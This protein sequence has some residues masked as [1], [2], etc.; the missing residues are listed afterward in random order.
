MVCGPCHYSKLLSPLISERSFSQCPRFLA[1]LFPFC[2]EAASSLPTGF[3][4]G[5]RFNQLSFGRFLVALEKS[6]ELWTPRA[7]ICCVRLDGLWTGKMPYLVYAGPAALLSASPV[8]ECF[9]PIHLLARAVEVGYNFFNKVPLQNQ[10]FWPRYG[11]KIWILVSSQA[12]CLVPV[13][14]QPVAWARWVAHL[15]KESLIKKG[16]SARLKSFL[17][18]QSLLHQI[19]GLEPLRRGGGIVESKN[20]DHRLANGIPLNSHKSAI[21]I[22]ISFPVNTLSIVCWLEE[23]GLA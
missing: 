7:I 13:Q 15:V 4:G 22:S 2:I 12:E 18:S 16:V 6:Q 21:Y 3:S 11:I 1:R 9:A 10:A 23:W 14:S 8:L 5:G 17:R 20:C 19:S